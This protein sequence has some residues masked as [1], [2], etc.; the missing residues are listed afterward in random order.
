VV[1]WLRTMLGTGPLTFE[2]DLEQVVERWALRGVTAGGLAEALLVKA[3]Q[4]ADRSAGAR[5][6]IVHRHR[7]IRAW[8]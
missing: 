4:M 2:Q 5:Q 7:D 1:G 6:V 8:D 3:E